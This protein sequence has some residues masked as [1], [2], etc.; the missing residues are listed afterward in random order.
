MIGKLVSILNIMYHLHFILLY[1]L[2]KRYSHVL[3]D[4]VKGNSVE[5]VQLLKFVQECH[6]EV[7]FIIFEG[8]SGEIFKE[9]VELVLVNCVVRILNGRLACF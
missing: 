5:V 9:C 4:A 8:Y 6:Y 2:R 1:M 7:D 3:T